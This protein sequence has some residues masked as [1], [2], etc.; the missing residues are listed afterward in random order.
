M[1]YKCN[2]PFKGLVHW[3]DWKE[4]VDGV[5]IIW[6]EYIEDINRLDS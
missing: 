6:W 4:K 1:Y 2:T 3:I 5:A